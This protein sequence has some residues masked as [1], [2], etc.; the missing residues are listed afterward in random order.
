MAE[1]SGLYD[2]LLEG[3]EAQRLLADQAFKLVVEQVR[4]RAY[5]A[6][7]RTTH[8][9]AAEREAEWAAVQ[10]LERIV[11]SLEVSAQAGRDAEI[12]LVKQGRR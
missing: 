3:R 10:G 8:Q 12:A 1:P 11:K 6:W 4:A 5:Q 7:V 2:Q 9:Q